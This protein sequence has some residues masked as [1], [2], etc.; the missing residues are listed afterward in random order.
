[1]SLMRI[2][3]VKVGPFELKHVGAVSRPVGTF[4]TC[5]S[6]SMAQPY[7]GALAGNVLGAF[8]ITIDYAGEGSNRIVLIE[9]DGNCLT[10]AA[11]VRRVP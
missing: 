10:V 6:R 9:R 2:P 7:V 4:K 8:R 1:M 11:R 3:A 5:L